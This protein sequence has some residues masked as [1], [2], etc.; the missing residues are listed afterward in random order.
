MNGI[1]DRRHPSTHLRRT[2]GKRPPERPPED[3]SRLFRID[4]S[5]QS[6]SK[7]AILEQHWGRCLSK[8]RRCLTRS[9]RMSEL[10]ATHVGS[11]NYH[12]SIT[13]SRQSA[14]RLS[15]HCRITAVRH[16]PQSE[17]GFA[18]L[19]HFTRRVSP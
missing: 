14:L 10:A 17:G 9:S 19:A 18:A 16:A 3:V 5:G 12:E 1:V 4:P 13:I 15:A 2:E 6:L 8:C 7:S 11:M